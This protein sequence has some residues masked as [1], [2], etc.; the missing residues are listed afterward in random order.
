MITSSTYTNILI[1]LEYREELSKRRALYPD[2]QRMLQEFSA[3]N[4]NLQL[5]IPVSSLAQEGRFW[6]PVSEI[7]GLLEWNKHWC[8]RRFR[9]QW[10]AWSEKWP[11]KL[12]RVLES[13]MRFGDYCYASSSSWKGFFL[14]MV[15]LLS[16]FFFYYKMDSLLEG[17]NS[18]EK[19][20]TEHPLL[21]WKLCRD[22]FIPTHQKFWL[23]K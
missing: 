12:L 14:M 21:G 19:F 4:Y 16:Y 22:N 13:L 20:K 23:K 1:K 6:S 17:S 5:R 11:E 8:C 3:G 7:F 18:T 2:E 9:H 10:R 15:S